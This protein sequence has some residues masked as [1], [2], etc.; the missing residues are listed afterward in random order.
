MR[1]GAGRVA[2]SAGLAQ[3]GWENRRTSC[4]DRRLMSVGL[5][6]LVWV[7]T[8]SWARRRAPSVHPFGQTMTPRA[9]RQSRIIDSNDSTSLMSTLPLYRF[10]STMMRLEKSSPHRASR[11]ASTC[12]RVPLNST[13][14]ASVRSDGHLNTLVLGQEGGNDPLVELPIGLFH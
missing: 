5:A 2:L 13:D 7:L 1:I 11:R 12:R 14:D 6:H 4:G 8:A 3:L 9:A 10:A